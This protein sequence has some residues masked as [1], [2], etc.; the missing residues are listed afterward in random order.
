VPF[1]VKN[2]EKNGQAWLILKALY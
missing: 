1:K 2:D